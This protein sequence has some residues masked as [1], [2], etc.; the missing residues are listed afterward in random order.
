VVPA[1]PAHKKELCLELG[2]SVWMK[3]YHI[4][5]D[6]CWAATMAI[7]AWLLEV[8]EMDAESEPIPLHGHSPEID[9]ANFAAYLADL[10]L[11]ASE[12]VECE[13]PQVIGQVSE[14]LAS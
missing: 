11:R 7:R 4:P 9:V 5:Y 10:F 14:H 6:D 2:L 1:A 13:V 12:A 8:A 3:R